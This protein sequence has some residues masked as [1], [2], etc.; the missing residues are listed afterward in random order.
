MCESLRPWNAAVVEE[1]DKLRLL[2]DTE[3]FLIKIMNHAIFKISTHH[4]L[5]CIPELQIG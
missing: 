5:N 4:Y 3:L 1:F 2:S